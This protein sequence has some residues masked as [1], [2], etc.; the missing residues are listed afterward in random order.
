MLVGDL[1]LLSTEY[2]GLD[3]VIRST[4]R[5]E[6]AYPLTVPSKK[7]TRLSGE[8]DSVYGSLGNHLRRWNLPAAATL[9]RRLSSGRGLAIFW[10][11]LRSNR[12]LFLK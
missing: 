1:K 11:K 4:F 2:N 3:A 10:S 5:L 7:E 6:S 12:D 8:C 9:L